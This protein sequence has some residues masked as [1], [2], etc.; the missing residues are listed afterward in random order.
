MKTLKQMVV[1]L[2]DKDWT[3]DAIAKRVGCK[4]PTIHRIKHGANS[5]YETGKAIE[6][7]YMECEEQDIAA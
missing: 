4:Q 3:E 5:S 7:L 2:L 1:A 6:R